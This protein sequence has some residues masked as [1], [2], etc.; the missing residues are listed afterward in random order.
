MLTAYLLF[1]PKS[2]FVC[3]S[4]AEEQ[5]VSSDADSCNETECDSDNAREVAGE[6]GKNH[7]QDHG[8]DALAE[9]E[10]NCEI[11]SSN[12]PANNCV[13]QAFYNLWIQVGSASHHVSIHVAISV[14]QQKL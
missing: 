8:V 5:Q 10:D 9:N 4:Q 13:G 2:L 1:D 6:T 14:V 3:D 7:E 12:G 11:K